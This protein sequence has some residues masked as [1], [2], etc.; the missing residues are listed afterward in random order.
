MPV[1]IADTEDLISVDDKVV[2]LVRWRGRGKASGAHGKIS[3]AMVLD[4]AGLAE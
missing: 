4:A 2:P 1:P 3:M